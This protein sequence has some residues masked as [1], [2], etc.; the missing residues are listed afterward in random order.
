MLQ[1][2]QNNLVGIEEGKVE[3]REINC[4]R[5]VCAKNLDCVNHIE[6]LL[7]TIMGRLGM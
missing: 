2:M 7:K 5:D 6:E 3:Q 1:R 4:F